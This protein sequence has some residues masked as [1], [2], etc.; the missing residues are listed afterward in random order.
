MYLGCPT[1]GRRSSRFSIEEEINI[2]LYFHKYFTGILI[3]KSSMSSSASTH[4]TS[5]GFAQQGTVDWVSLYNSNVSCSVA[6]LARLSRAGIDLYTL[7]VGRAIGCNFVLGPQSQ[8][9]IHL[10]ITRLRKYGSYDRLIWFGFGIKNVVTDLSE[11]EEGLTLI[12]L[13]AALSIT[14]DSFTVAQVLRE[15]CFLGQSSEGFTPALR[16]W[17]ILVDLCAGILT[18]ADFV[19]VLNGIRR[20]MQLDC[21]SGRLHEYR[22]TTPS[23]LANALLTLGRLARKVVDSVT[24]VGGLD[25]AWLAAFADWVLLLDV[26]IL[27]SSGKLVYR[28]LKGTQGAPQ[29][30]FKVLDEPSSNIKADLAISKRYSIRSG[31]TL[32]CHTDEENR[33]RSLRFSA[34]WETIL[35]DA[36]PEVVNLLTHEATSQALAY[37][38][39]C[40]SHLQE[41][42]MRWQKCP[43]FDKNFNFEQNLVDPLIWMRQESRGHHFLQFAAK[44][45]PELQTC[46]QADFSMLAISEMEN[47]GQAAIEQIDKACLC[48]DH[49]SA[50]ENKVLMTRYCLSLIA[51]TILAYLWIMVA[52]EIDDDVCPSISGLQLLYGHQEAVHQNNR[53]FLTNL[54]LM[55][56]VKDRGL[57]LVFAV[58]AGSR[59]IESTSLMA[60]LEGRVALGGSG[61]CVYRKILEDATLSP[62][63]IFTFRIVRGCIAYGGSH[64][65]AVKSLN[66]E[67][68]WDSDSD[69]WDAMFEGSTQPTVTAVVEEAY[70]ADTIAMGYRVVLSTGNFQNR[71]MWLTPS[72]LLEHIR[73]K[74][75]LWTCFG[76]CQ[77]SENLTKFHGADYLW[78]SSSDWTITVNQDS[79]HAVRETISQIRESADKWV[80]IRKLVSDQSTAASGW[81]TTL[82]SGMI[83]DKPFLLYLYMALDTDGELAFFPF[84][85]CLSCFFKTGIAARKYSAPAS[86]DTSTR[87]VNIIH[88]KT[89]NQEKISFKMELSGKSKKKGTELPGNN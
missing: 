12:A 16:Q 52:S 66:H 78:R 37:Y 75:R 73:T 18:I 82:S 9:R 4:P 17:R 38:L 13:C 59:F 89:P 81:T 36:F 63:S 65:S 87:I 8:Q 72:I 57:A 85:Q 14:Y 21:G 80:L 24:I 58:F 28:S 40:A 25:C 55:T 20:L 33:S 30:F 43:L 77:P 69:L 49:Q 60:E 70:D 5:S 1:V 45:L 15:L 62:S 27:N 71:T 19:H 48:S 68:V 42:H 34:S 7:Q 74:L 2:N 61:I 41:P 35:R 39:Y 32:F 54:T 3:E 46:L 83:V 29:V 47:I 44:R 26:G 31:E 84:M 88:V 6:V 22:T 50:Q 23:N 86:Y 10:A 79:I 64:F 56:S 51:Q 76:D 11:T 67:H 53:S